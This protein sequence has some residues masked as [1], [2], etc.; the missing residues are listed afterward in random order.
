M[1]NMDDEAITAAEEKVCTGSE[2]E[3]VWEVEF[4]EITEGDESNK[5]ANTSR[6]TSTGVGEVVVV[7]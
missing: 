1:G 7:G 4:G 6:P 5:T 2:S 3:V